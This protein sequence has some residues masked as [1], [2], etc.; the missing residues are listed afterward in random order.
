MLVNVSFVFSLIALSSRIVSDDTI[1]MKPE[2]QEFKC[3]NIYGHSG[4]LK[5]LFR[6]FMRLWDVG[7][8]VL[9]VSMVWVALGIQAFIV[10]VGIDF[11]IVAIIIFVTRKF[12]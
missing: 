12:K 4:N 8:R 5:Y 9:I 7:T 3:N 6:V 11:I 1:A 10:I 2:A